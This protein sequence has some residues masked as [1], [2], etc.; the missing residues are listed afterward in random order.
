MQTN[1]SMAQRP[2][3]LGKIQKE[4]SPVLLPLPQKEPVP[5]GVSLAPPGGRPMS[6]SHRSSLSVQKP[7]CVYL[8]L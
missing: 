1:L 2:Q 8:K 5:M 4:T 7:L 3:K 6:Q